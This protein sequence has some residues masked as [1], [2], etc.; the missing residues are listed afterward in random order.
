[1]NEYITFFFDI[2]NLF[3]LTKDSN[4]INEKNKFIK[5]KLISI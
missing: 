2:N 5:Y 1:M 3:L 4:H